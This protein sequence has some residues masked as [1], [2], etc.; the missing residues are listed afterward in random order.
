[1][2]STDSTSA[3][4]ATLETAHPPSTAARR[5]RPPAYDGD[6]EAGLVLRLALEE[7]AEMVAMN[8]RALLEE[9]GPDPLHQ[10]R[11]GLRR[12]RSSLW[13]GRLLFEPETMRA[14]GARARDL[15]RAISGARSLDV[16]RIDTLPRLHPAAAEAL[17]DEKPLKALTTRIGRAAA[18]QHRAARA[19]ET[20]LGAATL[21]LDMTAAARR[22]DAA[23]APKAARRP[24]SRW[25][26]KALAKAARRVFR[27]P[28]AFEAM[29]IEERHEL[30]KDAK[31]LRYALDAFRPL[32]PEEAIDP[33][34]RSVRRLGNALGSLNDAAEVALLTEHA[35]EPRYAETIVA[36]VAAADA[37]AEADVPKATE[38]WRAL[39][40]TPRFWKK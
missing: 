24:A 28:S 30:R 39:Q 20:L 12:A 25:A 8:A 34:R 17:G 36:L 6:A 40:E 19:P 3:A 13:A 2:R 14:L 35:P 4:E 32:F 26:S 5:A 10:L 29:S 27:H 9:D 33:M 7:G 15:G 1:M 16:L 21:A 18:K 23:A 37:E 11:V 31:R 38:R 22:V